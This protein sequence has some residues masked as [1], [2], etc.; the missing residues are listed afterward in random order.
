MREILFISHA[1]PMD[2][3]FAVWLATKLQLHGYK[4]WVDVQELDP[5][6]DFWKTIE[7]TIRDETVKFLFVASC[8]S[9]SGKRDGV[10]KELAV[11]D[12]VRKTLDDFIVPLRIDNV[13]FDSFPVEIIRQNAIDFKGDWAIGLVNLLE[14]LEKKKVPKTVKKSDDMELALSRWRS[15]KSSVSNFPIQNEEYYYSNLYPVILPKHLYSYHAQ[16][17]EEVLKSNHIPMCKKGSIVVSLICPECL[18]KLCCCK[19]ESCSFNFRETLL[20]L[21]EISVWGIK[22][23]GI[24]RICTDLLGWTIGEFFYKKKM[25]RFKG[26]DSKRA[27]ARYYFS[28]GTKSKRS[29]ES[30]PKFLAGK[31]YEEFWHYGVS[32]YFTKEPYMGF[33]LKWHLIFTDKQY[34]ELSDSRQVSARRR[35]GRLFFNKEWLDLLKSA[36]YYLSDGN[37][38]I[39]IDTCCS[40]NR[41]TVHSEPY[42]FKTDIGY[43]EPT[44]QS[45]LNSEGIYD[46]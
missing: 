28:Y 34:R 41:L 24:N 6:V 20:S 21:N 32:A 46:D 12:R 7:A 10:N 9:T 13:S 23:Y 22:I 27:R 14:Y 40:N 26:G 16:E 3:E 5:A 1:T 15:I 39:N 42:V 8:D 31:Y 2:N 43:V 4:V 37:A 38:E 18:S 35:K 36:I 25:F 19:T 33:V 44:N 29:A 30:R 17:V 45:G 11:A